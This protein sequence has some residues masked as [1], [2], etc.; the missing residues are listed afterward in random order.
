MGLP[1][2][3]T[4]AERSYR[5]YKVSGLSFSRFVTTIN[6]VYF[7]GQMQTAQIGQIASCVF[8]SFECGTAALPSSSLSSTHA[9]WRNTALLW[10]LRSTTIFWCVFSTNGVTTNENAIYPRLILFKNPISQRI[11]LIV[12]YFFFIK[13]TTLSALNLQYHVFSFWFENEWF[14]LRILLYAECQNNCPNQSQILPNN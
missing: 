4:S 1:T 7:L 10:R 8:C 12:F 2:R 13:K 11:Y 6:P 14:D 5:P 3:T 9:W